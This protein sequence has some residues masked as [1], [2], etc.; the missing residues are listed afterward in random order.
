MIYGRDIMKTTILASLPGMFERTITIGSIGKMFGV[1]GWKIGWCIAP[2]DIIR[3]IWMVHQFVPFSVVT[4]L[5]VCC[6]KRESTGNIINHI[7][8][9]AAVALEKAMESDYFAKNT[10]RY[11]HLRNKL[12]DLLVANNFTPTL[13][14]GGYFI[15]ADTQHLENLLPPISDE[16]PET[17]RDFRVCRFLTQE[18]GV[19][20]IPLSPFYERTPGTGGDIPGRYAR[21]AFCKGEDLLDK[22]TERFEA[23]YAGRKT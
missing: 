16:N 1:T 18:V 13:S 17:R 15:V 11:E 22:A 6:G 8:E 19:T 2:E 9:A 12:R 20:A 23:Y 7:Q 5:Q 10:A 4:P 3:S 21:F 14:H